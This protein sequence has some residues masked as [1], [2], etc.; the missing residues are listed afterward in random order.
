MCRVASPSV[1]KQ[2]ERLFQLSEC[3]VTD[4][5]TPSFSRCL[6]LGQLLL[7]PPSQPNISHVAMVNVAYAG[8]R[9]TTIVRQP[10]AQ[11]GKGR[12]ATTQLGRHRS[13]LSAPAEPSI[14]TY[15]KS[16]SL[17]SLGR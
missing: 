7:Y 1:S 9:G 15:A 5:P 16:P 2:G 8:K 13:S 17:P 4:R 6:M 11:L 10:F 3:D 12:M 14:K